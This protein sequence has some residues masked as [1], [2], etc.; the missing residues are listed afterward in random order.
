MKKSVFRRNPVCP[1]EKCW[2]LSCRRREN[3]FNKMKEEVRDTLPKNRRKVNIFYKNINCVLK[4]VLHRICLQAMRIFTGGHP[5]IFRPHEL[6]NLLRWAGEH[7]RQQFWLPLHL[8]R[9]K[10]EVGDDHSLPP[11]STGKQD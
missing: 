3:R 7:L 11:R 5:D 1:W 9:R 2:M 4:E 6:R 10:M 8:E